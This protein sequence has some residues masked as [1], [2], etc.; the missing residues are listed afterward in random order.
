MD[1]HTC[2]ASELLGIPPEKVT[3]EQRRDAK[4]VNH[5]LVYA[6]NP[7]L[8]EELIARLRRVREAKP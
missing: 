3:P 4:A 1:I 7:G 6:G 8:F 2:T 5:A